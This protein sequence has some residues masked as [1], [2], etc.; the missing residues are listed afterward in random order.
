[1][2]RTRSTSAVALS[3]EPA[4]SAPSTSASLAL[5]ASAASRQAAMRAG[6]STP[7]TPSLVSTKQSPT[8]LS[9]CM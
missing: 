1:M 7:C 9:P 4:R 8:R 5:C 2:P 3:V 6:L